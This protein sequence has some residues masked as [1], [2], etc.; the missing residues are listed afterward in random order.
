[1]SKRHKIEI[2]ESDKVYL[3][4]LTR[5]RTE[6][7]Q[8]VQRARILLLRADGIKL[9]DIAK[10]VGLNISSS[11]SQSISNLSRYYFFIPS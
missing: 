6:Q 10:K 7:A 9:E 2:N 5:S 11:D 8:I 1:M 3:A 4:M